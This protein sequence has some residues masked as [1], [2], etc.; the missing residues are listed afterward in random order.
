M[1]LNIKKVLDKEKIDT[2]ALAN[3]LGVTE[4]TV[5]NKILGVT[6]FTYTEVAK[7]KRELLPEYDTEYL[8]SSG[9]A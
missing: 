7:I 6:D 3:F 5:R 2:A 4:R 1:T 9:K 8:F